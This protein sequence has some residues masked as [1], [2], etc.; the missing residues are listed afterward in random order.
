LNVTLKNNRY[1]SE[2]LSP[3]LLI[4]KTKISIEKLITP[5]VAIIFQIRSDFINA[6]QISIQI[7]TATAPILIINNQLHAE[8]I[9]GYPLNLS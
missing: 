6:C 9:S 3:H 7:N 5:I 1:Y 2:A 4:E 8:A